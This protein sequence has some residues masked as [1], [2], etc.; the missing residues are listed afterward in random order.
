MTSPR[1][2]LQAALDAGPTPRPWFAD[3][4]GG[5]YA[6]VMGP[7]GDRLVTVHMNLGLGSN[8]DRDAAL[9]VAAV[10]AL[11]DLL[12]ENAALR[13]VAR[14]AKRYRALA[15]LRGGWEAGIDLDVALVAARPYL[16]GGD[17]E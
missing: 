13:E 9:I 11:P 8:P 1:D 4:D 17:R 2:A 16:E 12:A 6:L 14:R 7:D 15:G 10:N 5:A 3:E